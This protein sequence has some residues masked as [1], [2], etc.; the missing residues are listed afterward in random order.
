[1]AMLL[2][3]RSGLLSGVRRRTGLGRLPEWV[4][5]HHRLCSCVPV[6]GGQEFL[7][8]L[9]VAIGRMTHKKV[10]V[11]PPSFTCV[12]DWLEQP[13]AFEVLRSGSGSSSSSAWCE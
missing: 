2:R 12:R 1:M 3:A 10:L 11:R 9:A 6:A 13:G 8:G 5:A 7:P 4:G